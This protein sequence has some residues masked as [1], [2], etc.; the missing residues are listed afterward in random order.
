MTQNGYIWSFKWI[1][2]WFFK[3]FFVSYHPLIHSLLR[4]SSFGP[5]RGLL[6]DLIALL[7][8]EWNLAVELVEELTDNGL[9]L[10][11]GWMAGQSVCSRHILYYYIYVYTYNYI[12]LYIPIDRFIE[13]IFLV[14]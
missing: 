4:C 8:E 1:T 9:T 7:L 14:F 13:R 11:E 12:Y 5:L 10:G 6:I 2:F 3:S